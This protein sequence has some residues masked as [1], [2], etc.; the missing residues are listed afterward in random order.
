[1]KKTV[2]IF[3]TALMLATM[4]TVFSV[5]AFAEGEAEGTADNPIII[6]NDNWNSLAYNLKADTYYKLGGDIGNEKSKITSGFGD[7]PS[8]SQFDGDG[9]T[10]WTT[11]RLFNSNYGKI[12][13]LTVAGTVTSGPAALC[14]YNKGTITRCINR[15]DMQNGK[16]I[17]SGICWY[18]YGT[19]NCC[20]NYGTLAGT[21]ASGICNQNGNTAISGVIINC[22][23][24]GKIEAKT[25]DGAGICVQNNSTAL[26]CVNTGSVT[27]TS[28]AVGITFDRPNYATVALC[29]NCSLP[30]GV[31]KILF[32]SE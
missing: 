4:F 12:R 13:N 27:A 2:S 7:I 26:N 29:F 17:V 24:H 31:K 5:P 6:T 15:A 18:N 9:Y 3:L 23:N 16:N 20:E 19:I 32:D 21:S 22:I 10:V 14:S 11:E 25:A 28:S 8:G 1:M 30:S